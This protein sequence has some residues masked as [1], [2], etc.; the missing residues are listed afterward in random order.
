[1]N[2]GDHERGWR[3][4]EHAK[5]ARGTSWVKPIHGSVAAGFQED[6]SPHNLKITV[7]Q[8]N[9]VFQGR[10]ILPDQTPS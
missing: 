10:P 2:S 1:M 4:R 7:L 5:G 8:R 3:N 6:P 9:S